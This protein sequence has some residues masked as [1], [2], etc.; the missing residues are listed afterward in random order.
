ML[1]SACVDPGLNN[2]FSAKNAQDKKKNGALG[3]SFTNPTARMFSLLIKSI[4]CVT[5]EW[6]YVKI[7][8]KVFYL[9]VLGI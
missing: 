8:F 7:L 9:L 2:H 1:H 5:C 3:L 4:S 6:N